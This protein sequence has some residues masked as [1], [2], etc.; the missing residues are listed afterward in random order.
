[1]LLA[2]VEATPHGGSLSVLVRLGPLLPL[3]LVALW[4]ALVRARRADRQDALVLGAALATGFAGAIHLAL[5]ADHVE[6]GLGVAAFFAAAGIAQVVLAGVVGVRRTGPAG[7]AGLV[8]VSVGLLVLYGVSRVLS[9]PGVD[10]EAVDAVGLLTKLAEAAGASLA[11]A[12]LA[13]RPLRLP[14]RAAGLAALTLVAAVVAR[15]AFGLGPTLAQVGAAVVGA[16]LATAVLGGAT[17]GGV[18]RAVVDAAAL[19]LVLRADGVAL[20]VLA[21]AG[22][23]V[24]RSAGRRLPVPIFAPLAVAGLGVLL[25]PGA[26]G[27]Y[28]ILHVA[29]PGEP[30]AALVAVA[31]AS[32]LAVVARANGALS[33]GGAFVAAHLAFQGVRLLAGRTSLEAVEVPG[34]SFGLFLVAIVVLADPDVTAGRWRWAL[35][36]GVVAG[37]LDVFLRD[38]GVAYPALTG[39]ALGVAVA[40]LGQLVAARVR[41]GTTVATRTS[42]P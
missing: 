41:R 20:Y 2:H 29:H 36:A 35:S 30:W 6:E 37:A 24:V 18:R 25:L 1:M 31:L 21:G 5:V 16:W 19:S 33:A 34:A 10:R 3:A 22:A 14:T 39:V 26:G 15:P 8:F 27:R 38:T 32:A 13:G 9:L 11:V 12:A 28:E 42:R 40:G 7:L 4:T 17:G 23:A